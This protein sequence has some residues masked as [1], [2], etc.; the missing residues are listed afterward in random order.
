MLANEETPVVPPASETSA[1]TDKPETAPEQPLD[2]KEI[3]RRRSKEDLA[4]KRH[5]LH[6]GRGKR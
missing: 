5:N 6:K 1:A 2:A 3:A 4:R